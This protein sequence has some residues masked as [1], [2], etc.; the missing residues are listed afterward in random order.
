[1]ALNLILLYLLF[2]K[3]LQGI[4]VQS[5]R[6]DLIVEDLQA[7]KPKLSLRRGECRWSLE[8]PSIKNEPLLYCDRFL[9][10]GS[11]FGNF[12]GWYLEVCLFLFIFRGEV[13][14]MLGSL[15][16]GSVRKCNWCSL[17]QCWEGLSSSICEKIP[18]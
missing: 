18:L 16:D 3:N 12:L 14:M 11:F 13:L 15:L 17:H 1:M 5:I 6:S 2:H 4:F 7:I 10:G 8:F 9:T